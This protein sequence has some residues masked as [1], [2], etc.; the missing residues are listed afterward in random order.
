LACGPREEGERVR[1][2][3]GLGLKSGRDTRRVGDD[4]GAPPV[5]GGGRGR[6]W[7]GLATTTA[8]PAGPGARLGRDAVER[9]A[10]C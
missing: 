3:V 4:K 6:R 2:R 8:G 9:A 7:S 10:A 1:R 5:S